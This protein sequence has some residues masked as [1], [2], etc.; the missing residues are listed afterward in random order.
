MRKGRFGRMTQTWGNRRRA[1]ALR[2]A[3]AGVLIA[4]G[5]GAAAQ[6]AAGPA[7]RPV[8]RLV[9]PIGPGLDADPGA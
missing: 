4:Q 3:L 2:I 8:I 5:F 9:A 6:T 1:R 7:D